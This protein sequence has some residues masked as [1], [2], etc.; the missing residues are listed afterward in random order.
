MNIEMEFRLL[1]NGE[2]AEL[3]QRTARALRLLGH[4]SGFPVEVRQ[5][6]AVCGCLLWARVEGGRWP[7]EG[8]RCLQ[9]CCIILRC[10]KLS[11]NLCLNHR[12]D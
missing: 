4:F 6:C 3:R 7:G 8:A 1:T 9:C 12:K 5:P 10:S 11:H 2:R